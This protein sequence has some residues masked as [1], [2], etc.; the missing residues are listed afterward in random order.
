M[1]IEVQCF[2][3]NMPAIERFTAAAH[4]RQWRPVAAGER[5]L[6]TYPLRLIVVV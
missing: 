4:D 3:F 6:A 5:D 1:G 2:T